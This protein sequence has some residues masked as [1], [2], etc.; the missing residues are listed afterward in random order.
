MSMGKKQ[1]MVLT[2]LSIGI[3]M[4]PFLEIS[5]VCIAEFG[6]LSKIKGRIKICK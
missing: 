4:F 2:L 3:K 1:F 6:L 5:R